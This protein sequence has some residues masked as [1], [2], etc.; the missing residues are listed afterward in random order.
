MGLSE[1]V[2]DARGA[3]AQAA[4]HPREGNL[5]GSIAVDAL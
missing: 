2:R 1:R 5:G 4:G 3:L